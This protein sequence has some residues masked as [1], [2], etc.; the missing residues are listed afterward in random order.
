MFNNYK[1][2]E[3]SKE[4]DKEEVVEVEVEEDQEE[5]VLQEEVIEEDSKEDHQEEVSKEDRKYRL[6]LMVIYQEST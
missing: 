5:E 2:A 6:L 1:W 3:I 4:M